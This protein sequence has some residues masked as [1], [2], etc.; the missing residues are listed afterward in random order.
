MDNINK[1]VKFVG[2]RTYNMRR[3]YDR[4]FYRFERKGMNNFH[5]LKI[6]WKKKYMCKHTYTFVCKR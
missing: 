6:F 4:Q 1:Y 3:R 5:I 2:I